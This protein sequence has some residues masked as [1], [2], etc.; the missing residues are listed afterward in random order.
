MG[1]VGAI[2]RTGTLT[3]GG[4]ATLPATVTL[5]SIT[6]GQYLYGFSVNN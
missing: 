3:T 4:G 2:N 1:I 5:T 6:N